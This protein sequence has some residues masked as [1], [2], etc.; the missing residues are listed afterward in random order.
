MYAPPKGNGP[1]SKA[2]D[3]DTWRR[4]VKPAKPKATPAPKNAAPG[5]TVPEVAPAL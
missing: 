3:D 4:G 5:S 1:Y 2:L